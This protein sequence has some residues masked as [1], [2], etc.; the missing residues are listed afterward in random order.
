[1]VDDLLN[2]SEQEEGILK[3]FI[4]LAGLAL[5]GALLL[6]VV[7][8]S[9]NTAELDKAKADNQKLTADNQKLAE[10]VKQL[11]DIAGPP[12]ASLDKYFPP[13]SPAPTFL[14]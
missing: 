11:K 5:A 6:G 4:L 7:A 12:P 9:S 14:L 1:M 13:A 10:Q 3:K 8:C 2:R